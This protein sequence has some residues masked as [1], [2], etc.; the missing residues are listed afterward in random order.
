MLNVKTVSLAKESDLER[1]LVD[2]P[3][4]IE[5]RLAVLAHQHPTDSGPLDILAV[6]SEE[7]YV[8]IELKNEV[9]DGMLIKD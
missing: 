5:E 6:D 2:H 4:C 7:T 9:S 3:Y 1:I 8:V